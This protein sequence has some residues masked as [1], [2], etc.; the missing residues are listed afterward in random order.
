VDTDTAGRSRRGR[1]TTTRTVSPGGQ[2]T[3]GRIVEHG[4]NWLVVVLS[5]YNKTM[6]GGVGLVQKSADLAIDGLGGA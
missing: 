6:D 4:H 1:A 5:N 2:F 3:I